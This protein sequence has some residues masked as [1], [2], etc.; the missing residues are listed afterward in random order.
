MDMHVEERFRGHR[1][2]R[3]GRVSLPGQAYHVTAATLGRRPWFADF[4]VGCEVVR[5]FHQPGVLD[6]A[7][8]LAW[9]LMPDHCHW[10]LQAGERM[11]LEKLVARLK[12]VSGARANRMLARS[13]PLWE[14]AFH[15][16]ALQQGDDLR[17]VARHLVG[18]PLRAGLAE[19]IGGYPFW[20]CVWL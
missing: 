13:G 7:S 19:H 14:P 10:L 1:A 20:N 2:L 15:D 11:S 12:S 17:A 8:L 3:R 6:D 9:V 18:A 16:R 4:H 5:T